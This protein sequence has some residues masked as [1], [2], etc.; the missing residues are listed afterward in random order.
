MDRELR[1]AEAA[2]ISNGFGVVIFGAWS[3]IKSVMGLFL[4]LNGDGVPAADITGTAG[5]RAV[6]IVLVLIQLLIPL[7][8]HCY[9]G[10]SAVSEGKGQPKRRFYLVVAWVMI[11]F[12]LSLYFVFF[13]LDALLQESIT[14]SP[15][16]VVSL[17]VD[18]TALGILIGMVAS[19]KKVRKLRKSGEG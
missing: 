4:D 6:V 5:E 3:G 11:F 16:Y 15:N 1:K 7:L 8:L 14:L 17:L 2:L 9:V 18:L 12:N 19:E 10:F 13:G